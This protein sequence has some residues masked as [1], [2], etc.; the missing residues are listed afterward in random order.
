VPI[1]LP[2]GL[3]SAA[4]L[5]REGIKVL[6]GPPQNSATLRVGFINLMPD[7]SR[8]EIQFAR[9]LASTH[10]HVEL[11]LVLPA[12][13]RIGHEGTRMYARWDEPPR[14]EHLDG[15]IVT[16]APLEHVAF[17]DVSYWRELSRICD[18]AASTIDSTL[19]I[20]WA[21]F[22]AL[23]RFHGVQTRILPEKISGVFEQLVMQ[24]GDALTAGLGAA[25]RCPVSRHAEVPAHDVPWRRGLTCL[26]QSSESGLCLV[27]DK[28]RNGHYMFN[29]LEYDADTLQLEY[30]RDSARRSDTAIPQNYFPHDD[31]FNMPSLVW[32]HSA[33]KLFANWLEILAMRQRTHLATDLG[34]SAVHAS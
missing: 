10:R 16:G 7:M 26:A 17:E 28:P 1:I 29:H 6:H 11:V 2:Q 34:W 27:A 30:Q 3:A 22:A 9:L 4:S 18:W 15:L 23:Y 21:A 33:K 19:Y 14:E 25:F 31:P 24:A 5:R 13:Y 12:S 20:C 8:T 32:R